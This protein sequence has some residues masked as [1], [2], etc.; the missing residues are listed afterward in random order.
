MTR[1][2]PQRR[3]RSSE[4]DSARWN[5]FAFRSGDIV[6]STRSKSGTTWVQMICA[7]LVHHTADF[8]APLHVMSPWLDW[9]VE[10]R[11]DVIARLEAQQHRRIIKTHTPLDGI[12]LD[13][14]V[15]YIVTGRNPLDMAVSLYHQG[16]NIDRA[17]LAQLSGSELPATTGDRPPLGDWLRSW[18]AW[19]DPPHENLDSLPGVMWHLSDAWD[20]RTAPNI[21]LVH[22]ADLASDLSGAMARLADDL[23]VAVTADDIAALAPAAG[24]EAMRARA[25]STAPGGRVLKSSAAFFRRGGSGA[26]SEVLTAAE[27]DEY[28]RRVRKLAPAPLLMW[29]HR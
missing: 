15:T 7:L 24:I 1:T 17:R 6:I 25:E 20:R 23:G 22:Y 26:G 3:Y 14:R 12:P 21:V 8:P 5:G 2:E 13:D 27:L 19:D 10:P 11:A 18:I 29:L 28:D 16:G 9:L 4:E